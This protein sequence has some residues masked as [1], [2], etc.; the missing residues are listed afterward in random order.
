MELRHERT[1]TNSITADI[2]AVL[3]ILVLER[4]DI[5]LFKVNGTVPN[6][7]T[8]FCERN[9]NT[10]KKI[11]I[12]QEEFPFLENFLIDAEEFWLADRQK[13]IIKSGFWI[14]QDL[15]GAE[16]YLEASAL[17]TDRRK[18][19]LIE[20]LEESYREKQSFI[21]KARENQLNY[22]Q[23]IKENQKKEI[24]IHCL[25]HDVAGQLSGI[26]CCLALLELENLTPK[27]R[28]RLEAGRKQSIKQEML[29]REI[30]TA[31]SSEVN[32]QEQF[33]NDPIDAPDILTTIREVVELLTPTFT[34]NKITIELVA[35]IDL[36]IN[37]KVVGDRSRLERVISNLLEN[38]F[39]YSSPDSTVTINLQ[40]DKQYI[41][42]TIDDEGSGV[43]PEITQNL[44]KKFSQGKDKSGRSGLGLYFCRITIERWGGNIGYS[45]R[46][47][48]GSRFWFSL[49]KVAS[50]Q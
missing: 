8:R 28:E 33:Y 39:R 45:P 34:L 6:W 27:G 17:V 19:L 43:P 7:L 13:P 16:R 37:W 23:F 2:F 40:Q 50:I 38:A 5:G 32:S 15:L 24:L 29:L 10:G 44:F 18:I 9:I 12:P 30:L 31:F 41:V 26:N 3:D 35:N 21:Q 14:Q 48:G 11:F 49:P 36:N 20:L 25:I 42:V 46:D 1:M 22:Q 4:L 47:R